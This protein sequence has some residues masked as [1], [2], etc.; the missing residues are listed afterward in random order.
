MAAD[1]Q[2]V[3]W[4]AVSHAIRVAYEMKEILEEGNITFPLREREFIKRVK[5]GEFDYLSVVAPKLEELMDE[6]EEL[7]A[8]SKLPEKVDR[9]YWDNWLIK[10]V[11]EAIKRHE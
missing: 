1:N 11:D 9:K 2:G 10:V 4:K 7:S 6:V 3:D 8:T 5:A